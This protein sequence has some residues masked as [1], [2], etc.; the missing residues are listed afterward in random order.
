MEHYQEIKEEILNQ[1]NLSGKSET[2]PGEPR[3]EIFRHEEKKEKSPAEEMDEAKADDKEEKLGKIAQ[4][5]QEDKAEGKGDDPKSDRNYFSRFPASQMGNFPRN[6][7]GMYPNNY[8]YYYPMWYPYMNY[9]GGGNNQNMM[10]M[11]NYYNNYGMMNSF[12]GGIS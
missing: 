5:V 9:Y 6:N 4:I 10:R 3:I 12:M 2:A 7:Q 8:M 11:P 1:D